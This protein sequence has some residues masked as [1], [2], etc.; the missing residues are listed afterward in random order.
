MG[1]LTIILGLS[2]FSLGGSGRERAAS[3]K[4][5][6]APTWV[7][8]GPIPTGGVSNDS[9]AAGGLIHMLD[10]MQLRVAGDSTERYYHYIFKIAGSAGLEAASQLKP[11][12]DPSYEQLVFHQIAIRRGGS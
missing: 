6:P 12:F 11:E 2:L 7:W 8:I 1:V 5:M 9:T 4:I 10:D 3:F